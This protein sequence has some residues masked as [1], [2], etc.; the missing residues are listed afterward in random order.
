MKKIIHITLLSVLLL[1]AVSVK[2]QNDVM[3][4]Y[5]DDVDFSDTT[6]VSSKAFSDKMIDYFY[7]FTDGDEQRF[8]SLSVAGLGVLLDKAKANMRVYEYVLEFALNGY[9]TMGRDAVTNYLLNYPQ[10]AEGEITIEE[11]LRLDSITEPYQKV[12][13]GVQAPD[14]K[15]VAIDGKAYGLYDSNAPHFIVVFWSAD[16]EY[17]HEFLTQIRKH[18]D[19]MSDFELVTFALADD[20]EEVNKAVKKMRLPGYHFYDDLRWESKAFLDYHITSTPTVFILDENK[21]IV[22]KPYD[23]QD[24]K[25]WLKSNNIS[26]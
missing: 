14:F 16:C 26:Y 18:L 22:C 23:W 2:A 15:G 13:V 25:Y 17:C 8:D 20:A 19:L 7:S 1:S 10:L 4:G 9:A 5:W 6:L 12:R 21:T 3:S 11:G 24:L